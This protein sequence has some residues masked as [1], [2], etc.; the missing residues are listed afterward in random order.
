MTENA[1][2]ALAALRARGVAEPVDF[3][4]LLGFG[5]S[6][7][8]ES[9]ADAVTVDYSNLPGFAPVDEPGLVGRLSVGRLEGANICLLQG[10]AHFYGAGDPTCM[11][12]P[13][14]TA[15][16]L[17]AKYLLILAGAGS[18]KPDLYPGNL[19]LVADHIALFGLNPLIG[20]PSDESI[21]PLHDAYDPRLQRRLKRA[22]AAAGVP[23]QEGV[24]MWVSGPTFSTPAEGRMARQLGADAI[25]F[26][27]A[28][29]TIL[30]RRL[31]LRVAAVAAATH[32]AAGL[33]ASEP[34][35]AE[36]QSHTLAAVVPLRRLLRAFVKTADTL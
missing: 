12:T 32:F 17:G 28:P 29:E 33:Q 14:Q 7:W 15:R 2:L 16:L 1:D 27:V 11:M 20:L 22:A 9:L 25:G 3:A 31:G 24:F 23:L 34:S 5:L 35:L 13:L 36:G 21:F 8:S 10:Q 4:V 19:M 18:V 26:G 6:G 30:A